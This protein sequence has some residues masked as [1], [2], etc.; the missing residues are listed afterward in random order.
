MKSGT[1]LTLKGS[2]LFC[3]ICDKEYDCASSVR[4]FY[5]TMLC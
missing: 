2:F 1:T 3:N 5:H 4:V